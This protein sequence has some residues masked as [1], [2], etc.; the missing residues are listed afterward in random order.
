MSKNFRTQPIP[1]IAQRRIKRNASGK[2]EYP[3][4]VVQKP[5]RGDIYPIDKKLMKSILERIP[6]EYIYGLKKIALHSRKNNEIGCPY[7]YYRYS[8]RMIVLYSVPLDAWVLDGFPPQWRKAFR[9]WGMTLEKKGESFLGI[10]EGDK[11]KHFFCAVLCH[12]LGHH[13]TFQYDTKNKFIPNKTTNENLADLRG[14]RILLT[15]AEDLKA[16]IDSAEL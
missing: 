10:W 5:R 1:I 8:D 12:E 14:S 9:N 2:I 11:L 7:G 4:I 16:L 3:R 15:I 6:V 13:Y